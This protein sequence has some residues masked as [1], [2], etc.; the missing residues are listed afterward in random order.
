MV[1]T[2]SFLKD[3]SSRTPVDSFE[4]KNSECGPE[5]VLAVSRT[6]PDDRLPRSPSRD[7]LS[8]RNNSPLVYSDAG[9][10]PV[11][12]TMSRVLGE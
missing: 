5:G 7:R 2:G 6:V 11:I 8:G 10:A 12:M 1:P 9:C 4:Y 3:A